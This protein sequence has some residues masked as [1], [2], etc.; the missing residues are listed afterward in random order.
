MSLSPYLSKVKR[1]IRDYVLGEENIKLLSLANFRL[2]Y[3]PLKYV[4]KFIFVVI[5]ATVADPV[6]TVL[7]LIGLNLLFITYLIVLKPRTMPYLIFD[8]IIEFVL[9][10]FEVFLLVY[11]MLDG[12]KIDMMSIVTH[13][14][15]FITANLS[16]IAAIILNLVAYYNIFM[17]IKDLLSHI[18]QR[19]NERREAENKFEI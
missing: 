9:L 6:H 11:L 12:S 18:A 10:A 4:R 3:Y 2:L 13:A 1:P 7:I 16:L 15:G 5:T 14:V 8:L 19:A 17:C